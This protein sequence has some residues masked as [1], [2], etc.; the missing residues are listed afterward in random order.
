VDLD[1]PG[2]V[3]LDAEQDFVAGAASG[4]GDD[5]LVEQWMP[6]ADLAA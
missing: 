4:D 2:G 3:F 5:W 6:F 1:E